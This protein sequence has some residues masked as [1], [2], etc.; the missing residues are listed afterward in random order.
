MD[1][2]ESLYSVDFAG[3]DVLLTTFDVHSLYTNIPH[4]EDDL[5]NY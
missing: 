5:L 2:I 4:M 3:Q 1:F